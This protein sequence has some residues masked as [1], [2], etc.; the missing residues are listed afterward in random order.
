MLLEHA[1]GNGRAVAAEAVDHQVSILRQF[2]HVPRQ[3]GQGNIQTARDS[4]AR[5]FRGGTNIQHEV[6]VTCFHAPSQLVAIDPFQG[7]R[8]RLG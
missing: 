5:V 6:G 3:V 7:G 2:G 1:A 4:P 8:R